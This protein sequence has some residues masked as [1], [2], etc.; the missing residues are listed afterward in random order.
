MLVFGIAVVDVQVDLRRQTSQLVH[1]H[2]VQQHLQ[3]LQPLQKQ[4]QSRPLQPKDQQQHVRQQL[5]QPHRSPLQQQ[6]LEVV[7][8]FTSMSFVTGHMT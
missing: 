8:K 3:L 5:P 2:Q 1:G 4:Q 7:T 6:L